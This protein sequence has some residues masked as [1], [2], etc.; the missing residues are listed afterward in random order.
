MNGGLEADMVFFR[1][2]ANRKYGIRTDIVN[3][4]SLRICKRRWNGYCLFLLRR[5]VKIGTGFL[6]QLQL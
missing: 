5:A 2:F 3:G 4:Y 1:F 6:S